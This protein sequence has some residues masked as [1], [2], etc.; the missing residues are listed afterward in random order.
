MKPEGSTICDVRKPSADQVRSVVHSQK[1]SS[2]KSY[3]RSVVPSK[4]YSEEISDPDRHRPDH[5]P[6]CEARHPLRAHGFYS[7]TLAEAGF[8][9]SIRV[10]RY[11][12]RFCRRTVSLLPDGSSPDCEHFNLS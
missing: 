5:C 11:L 10:R 6:Q 9:G 2:C 3:T 8:E 1:G 7:R 12:C 4:Q